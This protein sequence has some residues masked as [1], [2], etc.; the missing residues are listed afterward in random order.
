MQLNCKTPSVAKKH[1]EGKA[2][3]RS[4][5]LKYMKQHFYNT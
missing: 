3:C 4:E 5:Q 2:N 1:F